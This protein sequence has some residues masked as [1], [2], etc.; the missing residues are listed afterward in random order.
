[1][2][3]GV[4]V[5]D[6]VPDGVPDGLTTAQFETIAEPAT[7]AVFAAPVVVKTEEMSVPAGPT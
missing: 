7:P 4:C 5:F 2:A 3:D 6:G 1:M